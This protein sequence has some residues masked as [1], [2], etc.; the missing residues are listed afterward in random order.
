MAEIITNRAYVLFYKKRGFNPT[1]KEQFDSIQIK[2]TGKAD[3]LFNL[4]T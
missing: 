2:S 1:T 3:Y 4:P